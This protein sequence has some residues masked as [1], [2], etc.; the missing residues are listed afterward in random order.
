MTSLVPF[1]RM[2]PPL[3]S[4]CSMPEP[5]LFAYGVMSKRLG[6]VRTSTV[7]W[8]PCK[9]LARC[10]GSFCKSLVSSVTCR[11]FWVTGTATSDSPDTSMT[12]DLSR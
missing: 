8:A 3:V 5:M 7:T 6:G 10:S 4:T 9:K 1:S 12:L 11:M 2:F